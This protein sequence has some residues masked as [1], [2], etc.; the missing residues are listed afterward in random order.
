MTEVTQ[1]S[2]G[3]VGDVRRPTIRVGALIVQDRR[4][5]LVEQRRGDDSYWLLP[6]G[7]VKFGESLAEALT[8][9]LREEL[10]VD[11]SC[12]RPLALVESVS[13][14]MADYA[15]HVVHIVLETRVSGPA[16][17]H[18]A[19]EDPAVLSARFVGNDELATL[20]LRPP[21]ADYLLKCLVEP[22]EG[23]AYLGARW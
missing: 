5:L 7:G 8:R 2:Q 23:F 19:S 16:T 12:G 18:D 1:T 6:G 10:A 13:Q 11:A 14:D 17:A 22:P 9:E 20:D 3:L 21:I 4:V 15:K